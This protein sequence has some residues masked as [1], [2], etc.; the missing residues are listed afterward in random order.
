MYNVQEIY[1]AYLNEEY[2]A[3]EAAEMLYNAMN[4]ITRV[5][6]NPRKRRFTLRNHIFAK[7]L[8]KPCNRREKEK[9][10]KDIELI[11]TLGEE[12]PDIILEVEANEEF[13]TKH[14]NGKEKLRRLSKVRKN[15]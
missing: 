15:N 11:A 12:Y 4:G 2:A 1:S 6:Y 9:V 8:P 14:H 10:R 3:E 13:S 7:S 5:V